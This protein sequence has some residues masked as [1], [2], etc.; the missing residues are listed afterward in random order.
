MLRQELGS[1]KS[2]NTDLE[3]RIVDCQNQVEDLQRHLTM[4]KKREDMHQQNNK[5]L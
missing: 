2:K 1:E 3:V 4:V 5:E